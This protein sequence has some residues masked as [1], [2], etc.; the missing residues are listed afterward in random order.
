[1]SEHTPGPWFVECDMIRAMV[2]GES[3]A[4]ASTNIMPARN[5]PNRE[6]NARLIAAAPE[7]LL[8]L[9]ECVDDMENDL[10]VRTA[11]RARAAIAKATG[12]SIAHI[13]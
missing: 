4:V 2:D 11:V 8:L 12:E 7:L 1:M 5:Y 6:A 10:D 9:R 3:Q 13:K